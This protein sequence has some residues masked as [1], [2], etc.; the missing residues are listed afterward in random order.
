MDRKLYKELW[1][2]RFEKMLALEKE[3]LNVYQALIKECPRI[4]KFRQCSS[5]IQSALEQ[6]AQDEKKHVKLVEELL[7]ITKRQSD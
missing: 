1:C 5:K 6:I 4:E 7:A 2:I 3:S